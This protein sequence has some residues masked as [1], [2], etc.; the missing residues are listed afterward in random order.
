MNFSFIKPYPDDDYGYWICEPYKIVHYDYLS[1]GNFIEKKS[2]FAAYKRIVCADKML[3]GDHVCRDI[4]NQH[5]NTFEQAV[6]VCQ[7]DKNLK[8]V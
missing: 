6:A 5:Y 7:Q 1:K 4:N 2:N 8:E 3:F